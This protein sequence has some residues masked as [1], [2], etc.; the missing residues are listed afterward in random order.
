VQRI[1]ITSSSSAVIVPPVS[2]PAV[3]SEQD[4]NFAS[5]KEVEEKGIKAFHGAP[6]CASKTLAEKGGFLS[7]LSFGLPPL[8]VFFNQRPG[9]FMSSTSLILNGIWWLLT[10]HLSVFFIYKKKQIHRQ[11]LIR[12]TGVRGKQ[13][14]QCKQRSVI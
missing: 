11:L 13:W 1:V 6:Y 10:L 2:K 14:I 3:F 4:W 7:I 5:V 9:I 12:I 8:H